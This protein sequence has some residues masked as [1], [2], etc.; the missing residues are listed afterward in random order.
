MNPGIRSAI[1]P[2]YAEPCRIRRDL[3]RVR[4]LWSWHHVVADVPS[5]FGA[6]LPQASPGK[7]A[8]TSAH[9]RQARVAHRVLLQ[10]R[11]HQCGRHR[12]S[13]RA[14]GVPVRR[15]AS[16]ATQ[17]CQFARFEKPVMG[18]FR[19]TPSHAREAR[20]GCQLAHLRRPA[21]RIYPFLRRRHRGLRVQ[22]RS[23]MVARWIMRAARSP[24]GA[25]GPA[26]RQLPCRRRSARPADPT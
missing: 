4:R 13:R 9:R 1:H 14:P 11:H 18:R 5:P 7:M 12:A 25:G 26:W 24:C 21:S 3:D 19:R 6:D 2:V 15:H 10:A 23:R 16:M 20:G 8:I 17:A 22:P